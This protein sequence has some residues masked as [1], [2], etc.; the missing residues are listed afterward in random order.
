MTASKNFATQIFSTNGDGSGDT[1]LARDFS[2]SDGIFKI[3][4]PSP[5]SLAIRRINITFVDDPP[6]SI[7]VL[8]TG[9][10]IEIFRDG[11]II[12][13]LTPQSIK[14]FEDLLLFTSGITDI[15]PNPSKITFV[16]YFDFRAMFSPAGVLRI[17]GA[18]NEELVITISDDLSGVESIKA[19]AFGISTGELL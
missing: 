10:D 17:D 14:S 11:Q 7:P 16:I 18:R 9:I 13:S 12:R 6:M 15:S 2:G 4:P 5:T 19:I 1:E 3:S 8:T